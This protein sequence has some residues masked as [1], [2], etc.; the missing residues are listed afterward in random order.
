MVLGDVPMV[1]DLDVLDKEF[2]IAKAVPN[3]VQSNV[4]GRSIQ[5]VRKFRNL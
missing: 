1:F 4:E 5:T 3:E 2:L